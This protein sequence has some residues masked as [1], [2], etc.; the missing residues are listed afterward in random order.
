MTSYY[1]PYTDLPTY[2]IARDKA[3]QNF[4]KTLEEYVHR[5]PHPSVKVTLVWLGS[6]RKKAIIHALIR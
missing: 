1:S 2:S 6:V 3:N 4:P 5:L